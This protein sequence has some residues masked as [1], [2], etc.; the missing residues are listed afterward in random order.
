M[1]TGRAKKPK[2]A[3]REATAKEVRFGE[4]HMIVVLTDGR[5]LSIPLSF[6]PTLAKASPAERSQWEIF[7]SGR[8]IEWEALDLQ[9]C[10]Q[11]LLEGAREGIPKPPP[12]AKLPKVRRAGKT[13]K[14]V[15]HR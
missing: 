14:L 9:L 1:I 15:G 8:A 12:M 11:F 13:K 5:E 7:G 4:Q 3:L 10:V 2:A 6:Y